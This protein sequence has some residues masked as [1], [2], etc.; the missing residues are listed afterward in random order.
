MINKAQI[1]Q[2]LMKVQQDMTNTDK[3]NLLPSDNSVS[4]SVRKGKIF[5]VDVVPYNDQTW[6]DETGKER[7]NTA[8]ADKLIIWMKVSENQ[9]LNDYIMENV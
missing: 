1:K 2:F 8:L 5:Y 9:H 4:F 6:Y 7:R 3:Y